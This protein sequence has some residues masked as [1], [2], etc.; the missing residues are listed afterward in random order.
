MTAYSLELDEEQLTHISKAL[1]FYA[2]IQMGQLSE[3]INPYMVSLP[4]ANYKDVDEKIKELKLLMFPNLPYDSYYSIKAKHID[5]TL[6]QMIDIYEVIQYTLEEEKRKPINWSS[7][8]KL[9]KL[10]KI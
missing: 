1:D 9:P 5:D 6:R 4:D 7:E 8:K 3:I 10:K 2:R